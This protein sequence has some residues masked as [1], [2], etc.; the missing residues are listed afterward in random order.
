MKVITKKEK[1]RCT[2]TLTDELADN[3]TDTFSLDFDTGIFYDSVNAQ[4]GKWIKVKKI[5]NIV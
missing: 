1:N 4:S 5:L 3:W 2:F